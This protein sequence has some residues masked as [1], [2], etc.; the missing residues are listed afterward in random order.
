MLGIEGFDT[1]KQ[2]KEAVGTVP[3]FIE[4]SFFGNQYEGDGIYTV[5]GPNPNVRNWFAE[6]TIVDGL[7]EKVK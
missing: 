1:K 3:H 2:L 4:T 5:V 7:I 6:L